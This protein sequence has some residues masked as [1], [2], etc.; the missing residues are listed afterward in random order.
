MKGGIVKKL[1]N[2]IVFISFFIL[3][4]SGYAATVRINPESIAV[5][6]AGD[7]FRVDVLAEETENLGA[8]QFNISYDPAVV[9]IEHDN[10]V[11]LG[12]F[13]KSTGRTVSQLVNEIDNTSGK[14]NIAIFSFGKTEGPSGIGVLASITFTFTGQ[15]DP[16]QIILDKVKLTDIYGSVLSVKTAGNAEITD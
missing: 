3:S 12:D 7:T 8:V 14:L 10:N 6:K 2:C 9:I 16:A 4:Q 1:L 13:L 5:K 15:N 11:V